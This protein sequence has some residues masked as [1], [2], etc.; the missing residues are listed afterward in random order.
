MIKPDT[1]SFKPINDVCI[2][3]GI[4]YTLGRMGYHQFSN[5]YFLGGH[6]FF[7]RPA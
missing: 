7:A 1:G 4:K 5:N 6:V 3:N 2:Q